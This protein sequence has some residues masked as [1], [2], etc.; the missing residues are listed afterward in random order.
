MALLCWDKMMARFT[1]SRAV[2]DFVRS[3][4]DCIVDYPWASHPSFAVIRHTDTKTW[5]GLAMT[6]SEH[7][8]GISDS[9][10]MIDV[11]NLK[12][13]PFDVDFFQSQPGFAPAYHMNK[14]HWISVILDGTVPDEQVESMI[15]T[16]AALTTR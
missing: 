8:L 5:F 3:Y 16:S 15:A 9:E 11:L 10:N 4:Y 13:S 2:L 6:L 12:A 7:T 14:T 1:S